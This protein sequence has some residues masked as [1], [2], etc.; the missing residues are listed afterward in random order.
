MGAPEVQQNPIDIQARCIRIRATIW[1]DDIGCR[2]D[3]YGTEIFPTMSP[4][5]DPSPAPTTNPTK[6][7][8]TP[9]P[10]NP[11]SLV[12]PSSLSGQYSDEPI[13]FYVQ[14]P[15][16]G[17]LEFNAQQS[18]FV[19]AGIEGFTEFGQSPIALD[20]NNDGIVTLNNI[21]AG[22]YR[23][24]LAANNGVSGTFNVQIQCQS[25]SPTPAPTNNPSPAP[26][27]YPSPAPTSFPSL[28]PS[29]VPTDRPSKAPSRS[30][31]KSPLIAGQ[32]FETSSFLGTNPVV[33]EQENNVVV[34]E[35]GLFN[36]TNGMMLI[37]LLCW[38]FLC[39]VGILCLWWRIK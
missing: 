39:F 17:N 25:M 11:G 6:H 28:T 36:S 26:T 1:G 3:F 30:P 23:F 27:N 32:V 24:I 34:V 16:Q 37:I 12:C 35:E 15:F 29:D 19:V 2:L 8:V 22:N 4:T 38:S 31:T 33:T 13:T 9:Y 20:T 18:S 21:I 7:P 14:M 5:N 10:T